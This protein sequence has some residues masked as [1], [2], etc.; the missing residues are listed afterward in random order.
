MYFREL[1]VC[2]TYLIRVEFTISC[3]ACEGILPLFAQR[4]LHG[5]LYKERKDK[6]CRGDYDSCWHAKWIFPWRYYPVSLEDIFRY[7]VQHTT[8]QL[9]QHRHIPATAI[10]LFSVL[11]AAPIWTWQP[12]TNFGIRL[13]FR[14][15][16][17]NCDWDVLLFNIMS[18]PLQHHRLPFGLQAAAKIWILKP[19]FRIDFKAL[20]SWFIF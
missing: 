2:T 4:C 5:C 7:F 8:L 11:Y 10:V 12:K 18:E 1:G 6:K 14:R 13:K 9:A 17:R 20:L 16:E 3:D 15:K 19:N